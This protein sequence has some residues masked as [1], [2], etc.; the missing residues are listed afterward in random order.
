MAQNQLVVC[1]NQSTILTNLE[2]RRAIYALQYQTTFHFN[3]SP[4]HTTIQ[5]E[6][7]QLLSGQKP[8]IGSWNLI[9][10]DTLAHAEE[11]VLGYHEDEA[12]TNIPVSYVAVDEARKYGESV[13]AVASHELL[14]T[15]INPY[16]EAPLLVA[17]DE[18]IYIVEI[19]DAVEENSYDIGEFVGITTG[20]KVSDFCYPR[21]FGLS[22][23]KLRNGTVSLLYSY[24]NSISHP[25]EVDHGGYISWTPVGKK[26]WTQEFGDKIT[27]IPK[28]ATRLPKIHKL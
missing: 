14:E 5:G 25:F 24:R 4:W 2:F 10:V 21:W 27:E 28:W 6:V 9:F 23:G 18:K 19:C 8:P 1:E 13:S 15:L 12:G 3:R 7:T 22:Q 26:Q 16:I 20:L 17:H 11:G